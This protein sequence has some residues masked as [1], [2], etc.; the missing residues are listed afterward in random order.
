MF[1][2]L[3]AARLRGGGCPRLPEQRA[4]LRGR[5][6]SRTLAR[7]ARAWS[8]R[9]WWVARD[10]PRTGLSCPST[11]PEEI[12]LR[13]ARDLGLARPGRPDRLRRRAG[14]PRPPTR[15]EEILASDARGPGAPRGLA[16][17]APAGPSRRGSRVL[18]AL[19]PSSFGVLV[20]AAGRAA[21]TE[22]GPVRGPRRPAG[23][24]ARR[25]STSS[26]VGTT[27]TGRSTAPTCGASAACTPRR[28]SGPGYTLDDLLNHP[29]AVMH[30][31]DRPLGPA[32][33]P[34]AAR[35]LAP[36]GRRL[37]VLRAGAESGC[38]NRWRR[39]ATSW[40]CGRVNSVHTPGFR[41][42]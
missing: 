13:A 38:M 1:T 26:T 40:S 28:T 16:A 41:R 12:L 4:G 17:L 39:R 32:P 35:A 6:R 22:D 14:T 21:T 2:H 8:A 20:D 10:G 3:T 31:L 36:A 7:V 23:R 33:R 18:R 29:V 19:P 5:E 25:L 37:A 42:W 30:E 9:G 24:P 34:T 15:M 11:R 27:A